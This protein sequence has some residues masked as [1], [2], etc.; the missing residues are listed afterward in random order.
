MTEVPQP[1]LDKDGYK[2]MDD[3]GSPF[4]CPT[5]PCVCTVCDEFGSDSSEWPDGFQRG[6]RFEVYGVPCSGECGDELQFF[7]IDYSDYASQHPG[8]ETCAWRVKD[9]DS[10]CWHWYVVTPSCEIYEWAYVRACCDICDD[11]TEYDCFDMGYRWEVTGIPCGGSCHDAK[12]RFAVDYTWYHDIDQSWF[13]CKW[14]VR[15]GDCIHYY[16]V[17][18]YCE[19][20]EWATLLDC[21]S[22]SSGS[23]S[24]P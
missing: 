10:A 3:D 18:P 16:A 14:C 4:T 6:V 5:C 23:S 11:H 19:V 24:S 9:E 20:E 13:T 1:W 12:Q 7:E 8:W 21:D 22:S 15:D 17:N 2:L